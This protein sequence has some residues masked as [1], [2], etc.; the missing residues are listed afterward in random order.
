M[1]RFDPA[2]VELR[3]AVLDGVVGDVR[4]VHCLHRNAAGSPD[5]DVGGRRS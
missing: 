1:R 4:A 3:A 2:Y 5:G